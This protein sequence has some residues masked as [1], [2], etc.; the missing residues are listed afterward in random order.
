MVFSENANP[1]KLSFNHKLEWKLFY[2]LG[3]IL[4]GLI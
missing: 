1:T 4:S 2:S 3:V